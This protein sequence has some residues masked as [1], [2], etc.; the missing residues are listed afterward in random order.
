MGWA[1]LKIAQCKEHSGL[2]WHHSAIRRQLLLEDM[3]ARSGC[4]VVPPMLSSTS[5]WR[6]GCSS[7]KLFPSSRHSCSTMAGSTLCGGTW[8]GTAA[9]ADEAAPMPASWTLRQREPL[10]PGLSHVRL[11]QHGDHISLRICPGSRVQCGGASRSCSRPLARGCTCT[12]CAHTDEV[13]HTWHTAAGC[14]PCCCR[15]AGCRG[16]KPQGEHA[17]LRTAGSGL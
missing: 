5:V 6:T 14:R 4:G 12:G 15:C 7:Q 10:L 8:T 3:P 16:H 17:A 9:G 13:G 11:Q 1:L 2:R